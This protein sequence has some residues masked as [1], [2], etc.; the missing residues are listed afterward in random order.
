MLSS[1]HPFGE[2]S[3]NNSFALTAGAHIAGSALGGLALGALAGLVAEATTL[4]VAGDSVAR[5]AALAAVAG[6]ALVTE[7]SGRRLPTR[8][9]QVD[10]NWIQAYRGWVYGGG[11]GFELGFGLST[12]ITTA[13]V[14]VM[15]AAMVLTGSLPAAL[16]LGATFGLCRGA[17]ILAGAGI[18]SPDR[19]RDFHRRMDEQRR[20]SS[21]L[22]LTALGVASLV[23]LSAVAG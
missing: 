19:L 20:I 23:A 9:H 8:V 7:L 11:F 13:L 14:H 5:P 3:R 2:R 21:R 6:V 1:I 17:T 15:V 16:V 4:V 22:A 10:E 12:I 18:S